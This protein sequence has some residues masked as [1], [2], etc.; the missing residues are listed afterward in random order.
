MSENC[1]SVITAEVKTYGG[2]P[3]F[4][5]FVENIKSCDRYP[6]AD[7]VKII[8][9]YY[10]NIC[11][12]TLI[13]DYGTMI[14]IEWGNENVYVKDDMTHV[15]K[16]MYDIME[17]EVN[18]RSDVRNKINKQIDDCM[19]RLNKQSTCNLL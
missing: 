9:D 6:T 18:R 2:Y 17:K 16:I 19:D 14:Y 10:K 1:T 3:T 8:S 5:M 11:D 7:E 15:E 12:D 4:A 13:H